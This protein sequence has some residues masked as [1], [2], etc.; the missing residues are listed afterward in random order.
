ML[1]AVIENSRIFAMRK[2]FMNLKM[3]VAILVI[4]ALPVCASSGG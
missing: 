2:S 1:C 4:A 3:I